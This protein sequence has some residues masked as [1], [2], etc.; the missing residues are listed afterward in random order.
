MSN[1]RKVSILVLLVVM[2]I[3]LSPIQCIGG[4]SRW[5]A[6]VQSTQ[7][8]KIGDIASSTS[9]IPTLQAISS[10]AITD[11]NLYM[12]Q[13]GYPYRFEA[14]IRDASESANIH[15]E[16]IQS[17]KSMG[18]NLIIGGR[19]S[20]HA[21]SSLSY[22]DLN[23]ILLM[24]PSSTLPTLAIPGDNF[25]RTCIHDLKQGPVIAKM[26]W[27]YGIKAIVV[28]QREHAT[29]DGE[30]Y[31][32]KQEFEKLGGVVLNRIRYPTDTTEWSSFLESAE[33]TLSAAKATYSVD[34]LAIQLISYEEGVNIVS[35]AKNYPTIYSIPWFGDGGTAHL[36]KLIDL[37]PTQASKL[38]VYSLSEP[39]MTSPLY[40]SLNDRFFEM[41]Y[42]TL[43][44]YDCYAYDAY[45][46]YALSII[47]AGSA[48]AMDVK[49]VLPSVAAN[50]FGASGW[51]KLDAKGDR[52]S[53]DFGISGYGK[54]GASVKDV[55]YGYYSEFRDQVVWYTQTKLN[56][57][58]SCNV[59]PIVISEGSNF[60]VTG[61]L[62][63]NLSSVPI[64]QYYLKPN[65]SM[66]IRE[67]S[68]DENGTYVDSYT[69]FE[70]GQW[71]IQTA[72]IGNNEYFSSES[73]IETFTVQPREPEKPST[74]G[75]KTT[76]IDALTGK[77]IVGANVS[78]TSTPGGQSA[79]SGVSGSNG[80]ITF[81]DVAVGS[82]TLQASISGYVTNSGSATVTAGNDT[83]SS[84]TLQIQ[85]TGGTSSGGIPGYSYEAI[86]A[87]IILGI[88][89]LI[90]LRRIQ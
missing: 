22:I 9:N 30:Y 32:I 73:Y 5:R 46:L 49:A 55:R 69:P 12:V 89:V 29:A 60:T 24:S 44:I 13:N 18:V 11:L 2:T 83:A 17:L 19:W 90:W 58:L 23:D 59:S 37:A 21:Q 31:Y 35:K 41:T 42:Q 4:T 47:K 1:I 25:F 57:N 82:Y 40:T 54:V 75:I 78:S 50:Y 10:L 14:V 34:S 51:C 16:I 76:Y 43:G 38:H 71:A 27:S 56:S 53:T 66:L 87:G 26:L 28:I 6:L 15:L 36:Q 39:P 33:S 70:S 67:V 20:S 64:K 72:W 74:G 68:T 80:S 8:I 81:S 61:A 63:P 65:G 3:L 62:N 7:T 52:F 85:S 45:W 86:I 48:N 77:P 88:A 79:L 84:I